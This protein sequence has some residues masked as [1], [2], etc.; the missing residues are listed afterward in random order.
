MKPALPDG[1]GSRPLFALR[2]GQPQQFRGPV[3][4]IYHAHI[5]LRGS[6]RQIWLRK[7]V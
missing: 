6:G 5:V 7:P 4:E 2:I 3:D 1:R